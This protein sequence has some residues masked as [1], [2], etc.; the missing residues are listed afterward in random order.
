[1]NLNLPD[2]AIILFLCMGIILL[3]LCGVIIATIQISFRWRKEESPKLKSLLAVAFLQV[4][5]GVLTV[6]VVGAIKND[7][8]LDLGIGAGVTI[9]SGLFFQKLILKNAWKQTLGSWA[10]AAALQVVLVPVCSVVMAVGGVSI[11][12]LLYPPQF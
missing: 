6:V 8:V 11:T 9:L 3:I 10:I 5:L 2:S 1:M 7:P 12:L 4:L